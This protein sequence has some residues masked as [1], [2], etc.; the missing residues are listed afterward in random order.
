MKMLILGMLVFVSQN[1]LAKSS[2]A[3]DFS[4]WLSEPANWINEYASQQEVKYKKQKTDGHYLIYE[5]KVLKTQAL[6]K[7]H[8]HT[9]VE[10]AKTAPKIKLIING[11]KYNVFEFSSKPDCIFELVKAEEQSDPYV[12]GDLLLLRLYQPFKPG[13]TYELF[14]GIKLESFTNPG[15][16]RKGTVKTFNF[17]KTLEAIPQQPTSIE[18]IDPITD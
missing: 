10:I 1:A 13:I 5:W 11:V 17:V 16:D 4:R 18:I 6:S 14:G 3:V 15:T 2:C 8:I 9:E 12:S 7:I